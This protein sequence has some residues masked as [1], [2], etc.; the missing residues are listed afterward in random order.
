MKL[1]G[2]DFETANG[3]SGSICSVGLACVEDGSVAET[4]HWLVKPHVS[5]RWMDPRCTDV[6]GLTWE[7]IK[8]A[9]EFTE[10]WPAMRDFILQ[11]DYVVIH[12]AT[13]DLRHL[14]A[15]IELYAL[16]GIQFPYVCS[17]KTS[18]KELPNLGSHKLDAVAN[19]LGFTFKHHDAL[20][21]AI[22]CA[23]IIAHIGMPDG[24]RNIF[25]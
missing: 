20:E 7:D 9:P 12:N 1:I 21:D 25:I 22:A 17:L 18:R 14:R 11:G 8:N 15:A 5:K 10:V 4:R 16:P 3:K 24:D 23:K 19:H 13:F 6:H 2:L